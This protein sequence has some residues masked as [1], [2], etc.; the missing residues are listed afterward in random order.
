MIFKGLYG[1]FIYLNSLFTLD[2]A[3]TGGS[4][5]RTLMAISTGKVTP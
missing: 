4:I 3:L 2:S 5:L 1:R